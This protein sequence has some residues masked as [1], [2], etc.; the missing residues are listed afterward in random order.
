IHE[1]TQGGDQNRKPD[2]VGGKGHI[3]KDE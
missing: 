3:Q 2:F 1:I